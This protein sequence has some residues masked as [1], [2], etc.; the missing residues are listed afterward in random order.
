[1]DRAAGVASSP[2]SKTSIPPGLHLIQLR[3]DL[4]PR[5]AATAR[6]DRS[7]RCRASIP[8]SR[9]NALFHFSG[10]AHEPRGTP[11]L[12]QPFF[13]VRSSL[14]RPDPTTA[15]TASTS[16]SA[17]PSAPRP[18]VEQRRALAASAW[19]EAAR[20]SPRASPRTPLCR[21]SIR[22]E[23]GPPHHTSAHLEPIVVPIGPRTPQG[24]LGA[25]ACG[26]HPASR[27]MRLPRPLTTSLPRFRGGER[28]SLQ[29][30]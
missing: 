5:S 27:V 30:A 8:I 9:N 7:V 14:P 26:G 13:N 15:S 25:L 3:S 4:T 12:S 1:M 2:E 28:P 20:S 24:G 29:I 18:G 11:A 23:P 22:G 19:P 17:A 6:H 10:R 21:A 16:T